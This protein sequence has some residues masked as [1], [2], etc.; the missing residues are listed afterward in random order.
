MELVA[1]GGQLRDLDAVLAGAPAAGGGKFHDQTV[2]AALLVDSPGV[3]V[4][5]RRTDDIGSLKLEDNMIL[6]FFDN[7]FFAGEVACLNN[8]INLFIPK[9]L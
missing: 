2:A 4:G 1:K 8:G 7:G 5:G 3:L 6:A 9:T